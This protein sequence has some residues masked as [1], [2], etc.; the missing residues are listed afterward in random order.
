MKKEMLITMLI[1]KGWFHQ[2]DFF[3]QKFCLELLNE[4]RAQKWNLAKIGKDDKKQEALAIRTDLIVWIEEE[5]A[6]I[7]QKHYLT[8]MNN[9][10]DVLNQALYLGLKE[11]ECHFAQYNSQGFYKKHLDQHTG[12]NVRRISSVLYLNETQKGGE[13]A[14]YNRENP[15]VL[16]ALIKPRPGSFVCFLSNQIYH[17]VLPTES[18]RFSLTGWFRNSIRL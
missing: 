13:L 14:I 15:D 5:S 17:E 2:E 11:Y 16:E 6:T 7:A 1:E 10:M 8:Q 18:E 3:D 4:A 9:L 12:S